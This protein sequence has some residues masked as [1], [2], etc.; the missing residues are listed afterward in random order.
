MGAGQHTP[1]RLVSSVD[2]G[3][4][5]GAQKVMTA[6]VTACKAV[7]SHAT[8]RK[9]GTPVRSLYGVQPPFPRTILMCIVFYV[10]G[11]S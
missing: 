6:A 1:P 10:A 7:I 5:F 9:V 2:A 4:K 11:G 3:S 8:K